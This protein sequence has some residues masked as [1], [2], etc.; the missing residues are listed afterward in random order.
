MYMDRVAIEGL[1]ELIVHPCGAGLAKGLATAA[2]VRS[3]VTA[4]SR[5]FSVSAGSRCCQMLRGSVAQCEQETSGGLASFLDVPCAMHRFVGSRSSP[6]QS[7]ST[8]EGNRYD[9]V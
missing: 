4:S 8:P 7:L 9:R 5:M 3:V 1:E 2:E 6:D